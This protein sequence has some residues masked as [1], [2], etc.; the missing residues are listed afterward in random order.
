MPNWPF[1][2]LRKRCF[3]RNE[4]LKRR[5]TLRVGGKADIYVEPA[6]EADLAEALRFCAEHG[7]PFTMLGRGSNLL[8]RDQGIRG[9]VICLAHPNFSRIE[10]DGEKIHCG[11]GAKLKAVAV[12]ARRHELA[13]LEFLEGIPGSVGGAM[14][15][16][17]GAMGSWMFEVVESIRF[18]DYSGGVHERA[19]SEVTVEYRGCP[20]FK[21]HIALGAVLK[22]QRASPETIRQRMDT[23]SQ[24]RWESQP[25]QSSAG[26]IFKNPPT[27]PAGKLI[28]ELGLKGTRVGGA[29]VSDVHANFIV[30]DGTATAQDVLN[31]IE[32]IKQRAQVGAW[33]KS[34]N[35]S[36][37][38]RRRLDGFKLTRHRAAGRAIGGARISLRS[39]AAVATA[40]RSLGHDV[41]EV[42][43][44][45]GQLTLPAATEVVFLALHGTYGEDGTVQE[46]LEKLGVPYTGCGPA[47]SRL[48]FD[49]VATKRC[50]LTAGIPTPRFTILNSP[51]APWPTGWRPPVVLKP[52]RQG[53]SVGLQFVDRVEHWE[54]AVEQSFQYDREVLVEERI[55]GRETTVGILG[56]DVL[57]V[58]EVRPKEGGYD[59][60][61]NTRPGARITFVP[62]RSPKA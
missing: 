21:N 29:M 18:M 7:Q 20:L 62:R 23:F 19:A 35:G 34:R 5:T 57:P 61:N 41:T 45:D 27:I 40:L 55:I 58:V 15:M 56:R 36:G 10:V 47:A 12:E 17:A 44:H 51:Q 28:D 42:D 43:P 2:F 54:P 50:C 6:S 8:I 38:S 24:K 26:C 22:G 33:H 3:V 37:N 4:P 30:N 52:V 32:V 13:G 1:A 11:A 25:N 9:V 16:N 39:G 31:L 46:Q 14:R 60:A 53:S 49:K 59:Y 48:A